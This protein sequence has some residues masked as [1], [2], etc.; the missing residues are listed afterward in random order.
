LSREHG[1]LLP[2]DSNVSLAPPTRLSA[3][4]SGSRRLDKMLK[5]ELKTT[6]EMGKFEGRQQWLQIAHCDGHLGAI[7]L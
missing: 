7:R 3:I 4:R 1:D 5:M 2:L 6:M